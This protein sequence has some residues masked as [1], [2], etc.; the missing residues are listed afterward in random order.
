MQVSEGTCTCFLLVGQEVVT[1]KDPRI[2]VGK[3]AT[4]AFLMYGVKVQI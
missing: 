4:D 2:L 1:R 3:G